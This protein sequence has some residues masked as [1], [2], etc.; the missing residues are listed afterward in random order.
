MILPPNASFAPCQ[1]LVGSAHTR[2][3]SF[4]ALCVSFASVAEGVPFAQRALGN[5]GQG[6]HPHP[7][8]LCH[9]CFFCVRGRGC[10]LRAEG[11]RELIRPAA[12]C[13]SC[14]N[15][16]GICR[17]GYHPPVGYLCLPLWGRWIAVGE[18]D[19]VSLRHQNKRGTDFSVPLRFSFV[20]SC[21][22]RRRRGIRRRRSRRWIHRCH[23]RCR[24]Y[25]RRSC[26]I[27][28]HEH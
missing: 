14:D 18:T 16:Q 9:L 24:N 1:L 23:S 3:R 25:H 13:R 7:K 27:H 26:S 5:C 8:M 22:R 15:P 19:E 12:F 2:I 6:P 10:S 4:F 21:V 17:G 20:R 28:N 11:A